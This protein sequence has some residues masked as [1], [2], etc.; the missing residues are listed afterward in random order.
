MRVVLT[1]A[2]GAIGRNVIPGLVAAGHEV[3]AYVRSPASSEWVEKSGARAARA[4]LFDPHEVQKLIAG[5]DAVAHLATAIPP[6]SRMAKAQNWAVNDRLRIEATRNLVDAALTGAVSTVVV[7][8]ITFNYADQGD[9]WIDEDSPIEPGFGP[10][11]SALT[12]EREVA[13]FA[14]AGGRGVAL[15]M[16]QLYGPGRASAELIEALR[17]R[18]V[19]LVGDGVNYVSNLHSH[20]AGTAVVAALEAASGVYNVSDDVPVRARERLD[21]QIAALATPPPRR[22]PPLIA[23]MVAG[24]AVGQLTISHRI[25]NRRFREVAGWAPRYPSIRDGWATVLS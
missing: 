2:T 12:A 24:R 21:I 4:D 19:P 17:A 16:S 23:R 9:R 22:V 25:S 11:E 18:K 14:A 3:T 15:R 1:G 10:T 7:K 6:L 8:S 20:D 13:R 5:A